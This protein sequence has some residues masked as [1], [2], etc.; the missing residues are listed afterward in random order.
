MRISDWSSD[1]CS[2]DLRHR[3]LAEAE[4][5]DVRKLYAEARTTQQ[6]LIA[7]T[8]Q[9]TTAAETAGTDPDKLNSGYTSIG[10]ESVR[11]QSLTARAPLPTGHLAGIQPR[12]LAD[13]F[14]HRGHLGSHHVPSSDPQ[15]SS[16]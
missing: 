6:P 16:P 12:P 3:E 14:L 10:G 13:R 8:A 15:A 1:V 4:L 7:R 11:L 2:S 5:A 9:L